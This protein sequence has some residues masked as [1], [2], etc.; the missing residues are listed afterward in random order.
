MRVVNV[1]GL[2]TDTDTNAAD[3]IEGHELHCNRI[4]APYTRGRV[5]ISQSVQDEDDRTS[6]ASNSLAVRQPSIDSEYL[7]ALASTATYVGSSDDQEKHDGSK[8][9]LAGKFSPLKTLSSAGRRRSSL[10]LPT[11]PDVNADQLENQFNVH[12]EKRLF[13]WLFSRSIPPIPEPEE[14][15]EFQWKRARGLWR[16]NFWWL[17]PILKKGYLRTLTPNDLWLLTNDMKV[18]TMHE[19]FEGKLAEVISKAQASH[20]QKN[21]DL[22]DFKWPGYAI[23]WAL[24]LT[25]KWQYTLSCSLLSAAFCCQSLSPLVTKPLINFVGDRAFGLETSNNK[26]IG[27]TVAAV[28]IIYINGVLVNHFFYL[29][30]MTGALCK[31]V[32]TKSVLQ[33]SF[34]LSAR[35]RYLFNVGRITSLMSTD[36]ARIDLAIGY[37]PFIVC[38]PIPIVASVALLLVNLGVTSLAGIGLFIVSLSICVILTKKLYDVREIVVRHTDERIRL[39][40]EVLTNLKIVKFYAWENAYRKNITA[41]RQREMKALL[42]IKMMR[43][44]VTAYAVTLPVLS[45][46]LS[47]VTL[48]KVGHMGSPGNVFSSLLLFSILAQS[49]MLLPFALASG[50]DAYI[51]FKRCR[52]FLSAEEVGASSGQLGPPG[53]RYS[54]SSLEYV[55]QARPMI[56]VSHANFVWETFYDDLD[57]SLWDDCESQDKASLKK[58]KNDKKKIKVALLQMSSRESNAEKCAAGL[59]S[60]GS[61]AS[62]ASHSQFSGLHDVCLSIERGE[63]VIVMGVIGLGKSSLLNALAGYM[64]IENSNEGNMVANGEILFCSTPWIQ[65]STVRENILFGKPYDREAY[66]R[67]IYACALGDDLKQFP[68]GDH[69]EIGERGANLSGGQRARIN[70]AR[71][72]YSDAEILLFDDVLSAVDAK[73]GKHIT[74]NLFKGLLRHKTII[75]ATHQLAVLDMADKV[76]FLSGN[77]QVDYGSVTQLLARNEQFQRLIEFSQEVGSNSLNPDEESDAIDRVQTSDD[78]MKLSRYQST[79][80]DRLAGRTTVAEEQAVNAILWKIYRQYISLGLGRFGPAAFI[81]FV[82]LVCLGT[83]CQ[84]FTN[85]WLTYW[86][87]RKFQNLLENT[88]VAVYVVF[89]FATVLFTALEF[90]MLAY[91]NN[92][93]AQALNVKASQKILHAPMSFMDTNPMGR[94]LNRFSKDTDVLDNEIGE[95]MRMFIFPLALI[96]GIIILCIC[97]LPW[98]AV[99]V[100]FFALGFVFLA[101]F[102]QGLS[103]EIKRLEATQRSLV[104]NNFNETLTG[105]NVIRA[106]GA[107]VTFIDKNDVLV[108]RMN[109]AYYLSIAT[110]RWLCIHLDF[111]ASIFAMIICLLCITGRFKISASTTG[112]LVN[113]VVS[114]V[115]LLSLTVRSMTEVENQMNSVERLHE[116]SF[117]MPQEAAYVRPEFAPPPDWPTLGF[118]EF[119][120]V[121]LR[122]RP[123]LQ[124]VLKD[125][126]LQ[127]YPGE[128]LGICGRT[129]AGK[130]SIM[131]ALYRLSEIEQG[132]ITIDGLDISDMGL[133]DLRSKLSIIPQDP[134]LFQGTIRKNLDPFGEFTDDELWDTLVRAELI[135]PGALPRVKAQQHDL[136]HGIHY[137]ML[138]KFHLDQLVEDEGENFLLGERQLIALTRLIVRSSKILILD[139]ATSL[140]DYET[141]SKIQKTIAK[142]F[143]HCSV[144]CIAH[145]LN[146]IIKYDRI[147]VVDE[148]RIVEKG[149][150][151]RLFKANGIFR[152]M[153]DKA[154]LT[155]DDF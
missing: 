2:D 24:Y 100:P 74:T 111:L 28:L 90:T 152:S 65:N 49:I 54:M 18:G 67:V 39:V 106:F 5:L 88:Y 141:D 41:V 68:L 8:S 94:I 35:S 91:L 66:K 72:C 76:A 133:Y 38:F 117:R 148:G 9:E 110:S 59:P 51:G 56:E 146:T 79:C 22:S 44:F 85:T 11:Q 10:V 63:F 140:V 122:Y 151:K 108:D 93:S 127:I 80:P 33:K 82:F 61:Y 116:Y 128:K 137:N 129:G 123:G 131:T 30:M 57:D 31:A 145:R 25:F 126:N 20:L 3:E 86:T 37:Q 78:G 149:V 125:F 134:V 6:A 7:T 70:L 15:V 29:A 69:T 92:H 147:I 21:S 43:D 4:L 99:A 62:F 32:L 105:M 138:H 73:V 84:V 42:V 154:N 34:K 101:N 64:K 143:G 136:A 103:R 19:T 130:L 119:Q 139:E 107:E 13:S 47:F 50:A 87:E 48:W 153:C 109:E 97:Y 135:E 36:L 17:W 104:Y 83:F 142:E 132:T 96:I 14:R 55:G 120:N 113:Y 155:F 23:P 75:L 16:M 27:L 40:R 89:A 46:M 124:L 60:S 77:G 150:P 118:I 81:L 115:G 121:A 1:M 45:S 102:Y 52:D 26:G 58:I 144:L 98:F 112:L 71:S 95:H 12:N 53:D 114:I